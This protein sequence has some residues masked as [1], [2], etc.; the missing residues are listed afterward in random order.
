MVSKAAAGLSASCH[1]PGEDEACSTKGLD[2]LSHPYGLDFHGATVE[3][4][5]SRRIGLLCRPEGLLFHL[6]EDTLIY[7]HY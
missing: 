2:F 4:V 1:P 3:Q 7:P 5:P 6:S